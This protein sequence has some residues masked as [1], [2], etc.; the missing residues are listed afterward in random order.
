MQGLCALIG[1]QQ[2]PRLFL[3]AHNAVRRCALAASG[4]T[5]FLTQG[6]YLKEIRGA[7][8]LDSLRGSG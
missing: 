4:M 1:K 7:R 3:I 8:S 2:M 6:L 5:G